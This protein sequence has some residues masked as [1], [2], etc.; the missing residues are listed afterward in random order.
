MQKMDWFVEI[1]RLKQGSSF[2][3]LALQIKDK[4]KSKMSTRNATINAI[5]DSAFAVLN[6]SYYHK[7]L[8]K[9]EQREHQ[10][11]INFL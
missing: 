4:E 3:E 7:F 9:I 5:T 2:G 11:T 8:L 10:K 1:K 6:S